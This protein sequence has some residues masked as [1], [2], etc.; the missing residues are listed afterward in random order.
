MR[1]EIGGQA[2][3]VSWEEGRDDQQR[4]CGCFLHAQ[5]VQHQH[6]WHA[7]VHPQLQRCRA[8]KTAGSTHEDAPHDGGTSCEA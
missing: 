4:V 3:V 8:S 6:T 7:A 5:A 1:V 2:K